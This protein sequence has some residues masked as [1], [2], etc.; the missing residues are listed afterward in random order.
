MVTGKPPKK[1]PRKVIELEIKP[2]WGIT[3]DRKATIKV[4]VDQVVTIRRKRFN[5]N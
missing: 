5:S 1:K 2:G 3:S 4:E